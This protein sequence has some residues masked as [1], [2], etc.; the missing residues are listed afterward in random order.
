MKNIIWKILI[1]LAV[2]KLFLVLTGT[3]NEQYCALPD[4]PDRFSVYPQKLFI[5]VNIPEGALYLYQIYNERQFLIKKYPCSVGTMEYATPEGDFL[6]SEFSWNPGWTPPKSKWAEKM[7][8]VEP[9]ESSPLGFGALV[10][11]YEQSIL[12]HGTRME[13][14]LGKPA[15]HGCI[16]LS[17]SNITELLKYIQSSIPNSAGAPD[18]AAYRAKPTECVRVYL[19]RPVA[20]KLVYRRMERNGQQ[21]NIYSD[22]YTREHLNFTTINQQNILAGV[23]ENQYY[24]LT[25]L[26]SAKQLLVGAESLSA[27]PYPY[28][29]NKV[30]SGRRYYASTKARL[31]VR[32][33]NRFGEASTWSTMQARS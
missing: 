4:F 14:D 7:E 31:F 11:N 18:V 1:V 3:A 6:A 23:S 17:N 8:P 10:V 5:E 26:C 12:I 2:L 25:D 22:V 32:Y 33:M 20:V 9:G 19:S 15:S 28:T 30:K 27:T 24:I 13:S 16:R 29:G 21:V